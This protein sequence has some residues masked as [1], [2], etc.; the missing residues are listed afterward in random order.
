MR[1]ISIIYVAGDNMNVESF[2][3]KSKSTQQ[4]ID[5]IAKLSLSDSKEAINDL[6][7]F[8]IIKDKHTYDKHIIPKI[9]C[10]GF[11]YKG[12]KGIRTMKNALY[13]SSGSI[14]PFAI[15][16]SIWLASKGKK[17]YQMIPNNIELTPPLNESPSQEAIEES[18]C[19]FR[20][21]VTESKVN[22]ELFDKLINF[23]FLNSKKDH[24]SDNVN[25]HKDFHRI[26]SETSLNITDKLIDEFGTLIKGR[27]K[28]EKYQ[29]YLM[30]NPVLL[31]PLASKIISKQKLGIEYI[32]DFVLKR[33]D[34]KYTVV[35]IEKPS[36]N[37]FT[38][39]D[40]FSSNFYHAFGQ[41]IDFLEWVDN[42]SEYAR[43]LMPGISSPKGLLVIGLRSEMSKR[44]QNK[45]KRFCFNSSEIMIFTYD[46]L[47]NKAKDLYT[48]IIDFDIFDQ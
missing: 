3:E 20:E 44:Q 47:L 32:T 36:D 13:E 39:N 43:K 12:K 31:D 25:Y 11:I 21:I 29:T 24:S 6:F 41:V 26:I 37:I 14:Y 5:K 38:K 17:N 40:D 30:N 34:N 10:H 1:K 4:I 45:F 15:I 46:D 35:E 22:K 8:L 2:L 9:A 7:D 42:N 48:N 33:L 23:Y 27:Y 16:Q 18:K 19:V 28:E